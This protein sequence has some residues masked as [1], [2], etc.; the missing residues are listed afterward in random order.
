M[1]VTMGPIRGG[2]EWFTVTFDNGEVVLADPTVDEVVEA[3]AQDIA[4]V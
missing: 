1:S 2:I 3:P 4:D